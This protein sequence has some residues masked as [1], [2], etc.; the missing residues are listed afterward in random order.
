MND[1][2]TYIMGYNPFTFVNI[3]RLQVLVFRHLFT[4]IIPSFCMPML[5]SFF[6]TSM[7]CLSLS[8]HS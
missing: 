4:T 5:I 8:T 6:A 1:M 7:Y 2:I 3:I